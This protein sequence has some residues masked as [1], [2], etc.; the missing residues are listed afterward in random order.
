M[1]TNR[2]LS[3]LLEAGAV[4]SAHNNGGLT[5]LMMAANDGHEQVALVLL[6]AGAVVYCIEH[7][8]ERRYLLLD[9]HS[10]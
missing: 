10:W 5:A 3:S 4:V 8:K 7:I 6:K 9:K 1:A 2:S